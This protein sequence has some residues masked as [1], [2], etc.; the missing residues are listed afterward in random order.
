MDIKAY[1]EF[2]TRSDW[3]RGRPT[4]ARMSIAQYGIAAEV[5]SL[6][7]AIKKK[8]I[9]SGDFDWNVPNDEIVEELGD[10]IWYTELLAEAG[11]VGALNDVLR[12]DLESLPKEIERDVPFKESLDPD[13]Y[14][15]FLTRSRNYTERSADH[16]FKDYQDI[17]ILTARTE[18]RDLLHVCLTRLMF[19]ATV[20]MSKGFPQVEKLMQRDI[21]DLPLARA[22]GLIMWHVSA[23]AGLYSKTLDEVVDFNVNKLNEL[24]NVDQNSPTP[25]HD[26]LD[27]VPVSQRFPRQFDVAFVTVGKAGCRCT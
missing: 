17:A 16:V 9:L 18:G 4:S 8:L 20:M 25:L 15:T 27:E 13:N 22:L 14:M 26:E 5:G 21:L 3:T 12:Y 2:V 23:I 19:Y 11:S 7:S 1:S 6:V 10:I 24:S